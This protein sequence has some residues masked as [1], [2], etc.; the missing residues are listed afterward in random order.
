ML[1][2]RLSVMMFL[3]FFIFGAWYVTVGNFMTEAG[4]AELIFWA[5]TVGPIA[6]VVSPFFFGV[7]ADR[8]IATEKML[9]GLVLVGALAMYAAAEVGG[10]RP[11]LFILLL[12]VHT[13]C[14][15]PTIGLSQALVFHHVA[16][17]QRQFPMIRAFGSIGWIVAGIVVSGVLDADKT[18]VPLYW[19]AGASVLYGLYTFTLPHTPP[20][21]KGERVSVRQILGI[22]A[23]GQLKSRSFVVFILCATLISIPLAA[24]NA[25]GP[26]FLS[27]AGLSS[28]AFKMTFGQMG[29]VFIMFMM[30]LLFLRLRFKAMFLMGLA[31][32]GLR[33]TLFAAAVPAAS[34]WMMMTGILL[35]G[36]C[37]DFIF[38][39]GRIY[40]D[41]Q[42]HPSIR[43]QA[44]GFLVVVTLGLGQLMG[45]L[46]S[47]W[48]FNDVLGDSA[49]SLEAWLPFWLVP[50]VFCFFVMGLFGGFFKEDR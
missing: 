48:L 35:H 36:F 40:I 13:L 43:G 28:P 1:D 21:A 9:G 47:G 18:V 29:E 46:L 10:S 20:P 8:F 33:Y 42:A 41:R 30:P 45:A 16:D 24:Y 49:H 34:V 12:Q 19:A 2:V 26:V 7:V 22:E 17:P 44:H 32:W 50:A 11:T 38:V 14:Y 6:A 37:F 4:M 27:A 23:L 15:Y 25:Y 31:A 39:A 3:Q 5:Y